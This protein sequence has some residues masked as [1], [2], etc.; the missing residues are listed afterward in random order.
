[1]QLSAELAALLASGTLLVGFWLGKS[2]TQS[3]V[4]PTSDAGSSSDVIAAEPVARPE[5]LGAI[6]E[7]APLAVLVYGETG[8][9][10]FSNRQARVLFAEGQPL[11]G[12]N[13]LRLAEHAPEPLRAALVGRPDA[14]FSVEGEAE[15][16]T[17]SL[18]RRELSFANEPQTLLMVKEL[19][20]ELGRQEVEVWKKVIRIINH[21]LNNSLA[22]ILSM[23]RSARVIA[24]DPE[25]LHKLEQ[26]F[27]TIEERARHLAAFLE[28]YA[29][30]ARLPRA[31]PERVDL[32]QFLEGLK[33]LYPAARVGD[34]PARDGHFDAGQIQQVLINLLKNAFEASSE[35]GDVEL[36]A[37]VSEDGAVTFV[38][39]DR[40]AGMTDEVMKSALLPFFSTKEK[41]SG[42]G[43]ALAREI[44]E[45]HRGKLRIARRDGGGIEVSCWLPGANTVAL[46]H[47]R[48][49]SLTRA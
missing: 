35:G 26:V 12:Q 15:L 29:R 8:K 1:M 37:R 36:N 11:E 20:P 9:I 3:R 30:F 6:V 18:A 48:T 25:Q 42:L 10:T 13:F 4:R 39:S 33:T 47:T 41:G 24:S 40:G 21:E 43:L 7:H 44:V 31:R 38:V 27:S 45:A 22:P 34:A 19:T 17:F 23:V 14:L 2:R 16:E 32:T 46:S 28:G 5:L 49:L